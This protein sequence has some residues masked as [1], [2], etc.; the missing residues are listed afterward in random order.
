MAEEETDAPPEDAGACELISPAAQKLL[1]EKDKKIE[2]LTNDIKRLQAD[3]DNSRKRNEKEWNERVRFA[4]Q[5]LVSDL[6]MVLDSFDKAMEDADKGCDLDCLR[7]GVQQ[8]HRQ[9][10]QILQREGL[11]E[12]DTKGKFDPFLHE[13]VMREEKEDAEDGKILEVYQKGYALG[14]HALRPAKVKVAKRKEP[15]EAPSEEPPKAESKPKAKAPEK[16]Y[17]VK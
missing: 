1:D 13:A 15:E 7:E 12:I 10:V 16:S 6:L 14:H 17:E 8:V 11:K 4:N 9:L 3:F 2:G 5:R